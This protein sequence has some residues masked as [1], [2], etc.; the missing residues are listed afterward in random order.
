MASRKWYRADGPSTR[1]ESQVTVKFDVVF[2]DPTAS[3]RGRRGRPPAR[4]WVNVADTALTRWLKRNGLLYEVV[5]AAF[6]TPHHPLLTF[7][8]AHTTLALDL[9]VGDV[10]GRGSFAS[11]AVQATPNPTFKG[12]KVTKDRDVFV[13]I[14]D[15][16]IH[17]LPTDFS[18]EPLN[19]H[20]K[21]MFVTPK[22]LGVFH[23][24]KVK[25]A[26]A[27]I[28]VSVSPEESEVFRYPVFHRHDEEWFSAVKQDWAK[29]P[30]V[31]WSRVG[32]PEPFFDEGVFGGTDQVYYVP[33]ASERAGRILADNM[34]L[35][36]V[37]YVL[38]TARW[39]GYQRHDAALALPA[40]PSHKR[41]TEEQMFDLFHLTPKERAYVSRRMG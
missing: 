29:I 41:L 38:D 4:M 1:E 26:K 11:I 28:G 20:R 6:F 32:D 37:R 19:I 22:K 35:A 30:K 2:T 9:D 40:I 25:I 23:D 34:N 14:L 5:P 13:T 12:T 24:P 8:R 27:R 3:F 10:V 16:S 39:P 18:E 15:D 21:M 17:W 7:L 31:M 33:V 36:L